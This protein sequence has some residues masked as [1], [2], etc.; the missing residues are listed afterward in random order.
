MVS[1]PVSEMAD[2]VEELPVE[3]YSNTYKV[4]AVLH[5]PANRPGRV[6]G[7]AVPGG[8][9]GVK[10]LRV[11]WICNQLAAAGFAAIRFDYQG[12]GESEGMRWRLIPLE[13]VQ[14]LRDALTFLENHEAIDPGRLAV[15][16]NAWGG[17]L[18]VW[19]AAQD[20]RISALVLSGTPLDG[21][22]WLRSQR[23]GWQ[24][25]EF[26]NRLKADRL[27]ALRTGRSE[28]VAS[29]E[30]MVPDPRTNAEHQKNDQQMTWRPRL[31]LESASAVI[32]F[33]PIRLLPQ[34]TAPILFMHCE[35]DA[36]VPVDEARDGFVHAQEPKR[37][38]VFAGAQHHDIY[39]APLREKAMAAATDWF[40][41]HVLNQEG[42]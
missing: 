15:Y 23:T 27:A 32:D 38:M 30:I 1:K 4:S 2:R 41:R 11:P 19:A 34:V 16:G 28:I 33:K 10:E 7:I 12:F 40:G 14:N 24:W 26:R 5:L 29:D 31:P 37:L 9:G 20:S 6:P 39:Y 17:G 18:A 8:F 36:L 35:L 21:E 3:F 25:V 22:R 13:E 42:D